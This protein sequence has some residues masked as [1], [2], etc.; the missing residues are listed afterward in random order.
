MSG[1]KVES[2]KGSSVVSDERTLN[3]RRGVV[4]QE[5]SAGGEKELP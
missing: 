5:R 2:R 4:C 3:E 1:T